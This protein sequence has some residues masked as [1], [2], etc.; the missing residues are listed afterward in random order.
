MG[1]IQPRLKAS[2]PLPPAGAGTELPV[3][4]S[5]A[6]AISH[7]VPGAGCPPVP[8]APLLPGSLHPLGADSSTRPSLT[9]LSAHLAAFLERHRL[10]SAPAARRAS[11]K[12]GEEAP[13]GARRKPNKLPIN[14]PKKP[15]GWQGSREEPWQLMS[16]LRPNPGSESCSE[17]AAKAPL[18]GPGGEM[19][20]RRSKR[21]AVGEEGAPGSA[22]AEP[23]CTHAALPLA[24]S[25]PLLHPSSGSAGRAARPMARGTRARLANLAREMRMA[26]TERARRDGGAGDPNRS[27]A[28][29]R[30]GHRDSHPGSLL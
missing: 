27:G 28:V 16:P 7:S 24:S 18:G 15:S 2:L 19:G 14:F 26:E 21:S 1:Q 25:S 10:R 3:P 17:Q 9:R 5:P 13:G 11:G 20:S 8:P 6:A 22:A 23:A 29:V 30:N 12:V 4:F